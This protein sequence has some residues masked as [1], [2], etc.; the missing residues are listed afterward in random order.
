VLTF[1]DG[2]D[3]ELHNR[4]YAA[5]LYES[6]S[7]VP[8]LLGASIVRPDQLF[9]ANW[10]LRAVTTGDAFIPDSAYSNHQRIHQYRGGHTETW[11]GVAVDIDSDQL[12]AALGGSGGLQASGVKAISYPVS[13]GAT[14]VAVFGRGGDGSVQERFFDGGAWGP[15]LSLG[16][17]IVGE[18]AVIL[19]Q[20][21]NSIDV[22]A[23]AAA[24]NSV[25]EIFW[26]EAGGWSAWQPLG[27][28]ITGAPVAVYDN[29]SV[30]V[31]VR[32]ANDGSLWE[33]FWT[34]AGGWTPDWIG[35]GG[36]LATDP[37]VIVN[38]TDVNV[39]APGLEGAVWEKFWTAAGGWSAWQPLGGTIVG[40]PSALN[41]Q[42]SVEV[43]VIG[44]TDRALWEKFWTPAAGWTPDWI[45]LG[46]SLT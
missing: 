4:G 39:F 15:W 35:L 10:D 33:K 7:N 29:G 5:G 9:Y 12:D 41:D 19:N 16:G 31:Y 34:P 25:W 2:Y 14:D 28:T 21:D 8:D 30:E 11:G 44:A 32:A 40:A 20:N 45:G 6:A 26:T 22:F 13:S 17:S 1:L 27:G 42:G 43:Y 37:S 24:D 23:R 36:N 46:G 38:G 18:P 3:T